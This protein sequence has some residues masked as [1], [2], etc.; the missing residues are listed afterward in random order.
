MMLVLR[1]Q[2]CP[3]N[4]ACSQSIYRSVTP[5]AT[6][7]WLWLPFWTGSTRMTAPF[8]LPDSFSCCSD[9]VA[10]S[11]VDQEGRKRDIITITLTKTVVANV[12]QW[13][14]SSLPQDHLTLNEPS[15]KSAPRQTTIVKSVTNKRD[16]QHNSVIR[17]TDIGLGLSELGILEFLW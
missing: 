3:P 13:G 12:K 8:F 11:V 2:N 15:L 9:A 16:M 17:Y 1:R 4:R 10:L 5:A 14:L 7:D 6:C